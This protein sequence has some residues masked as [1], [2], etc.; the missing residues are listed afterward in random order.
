MIQTIFFSTEDLV[1]VFSSEISK[2]KSVS[3]LTQS[4]LH[5][6]DLISPCVNEIPPNWED[7][8]LPSLDIPLAGLKS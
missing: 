7:W 6:N 8:P 1:L 3:T 5:L 4:L 2:Q